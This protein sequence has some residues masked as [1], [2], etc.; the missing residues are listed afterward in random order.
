MDVGGG[1][2]QNAKRVESCWW[3]DKPGCCEIR[4]LDFQKKRQPFTAQL[5]T[6]MLLDGICKPHEKAYRLLFGNDDNIC[7][8]SFF[9][10]LG[11]MLCALHAFNFW[12]LFRIFFYT[13]TEWAGSRSWWWTGKP[14]MLQSLGLQRVRHDWATELNWFYKWGSHI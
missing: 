1:V 5:Q 4:K 7:C 9:Y 2:G 10:A 12:H 11:R 14:D 6:H 13:L 8:L 3:R